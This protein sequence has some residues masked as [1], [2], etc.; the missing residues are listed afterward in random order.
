MFCLSKKTD[1]ALIALAFLGENPQTI[2][3]SREI[4]QACAL[5]RALVTKILKE[6]H[7]AGILQSSR[8]STGGYQIVANLEKHSLHDLIRLLEQ[9]EPTARVLDDA[10]SLRFPQ[11]RYTHLAGPAAAPSR[12]CIT[13]SGDS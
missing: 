9:V 1:Y 11:R 2:R 6:L 10:A 5:P 13:N 7:Q 3:S 4:A 8:G 12:R